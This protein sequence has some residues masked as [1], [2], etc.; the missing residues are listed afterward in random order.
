[1]STKI[2]FIEET[3]NYVNEYGIVIP[4]VSEL[5]RFKFPEAYAG[6]PERVLKQKASYGSKVHQKIEDF[7]RGNFS[8]TEL[9]NMSIDPNIKVAVEQFE[10]LRKKWAFQIRDMEQ[11]VDYKERYAGTYDILTIDDLVID[12]KTTSEVHE[13]WLSWQIGLYQTALGIEN[14]VGYCIWLPKGKTGKVV[15]IKPKTKQE[16]LSLL[17]DYEQANKSFTDFQEN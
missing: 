6:V 16:C 10:S 5:I 14:D 9:Q 4:S 3:H 1:M 2:E 15:A 12:L 8:L 11:I 13:E 17:E 7:V